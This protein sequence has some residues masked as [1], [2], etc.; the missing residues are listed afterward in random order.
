MREVEP[1]DLK[2][3]AKIAQLLIEGKKGADLDIAIQ[4]FDKS[5]VPE[6][7]TRFEAPITARHYRR[8]SSAP[9]PDTEHSHPPSVKQEEEVSTPS[10]RK[11]KARSSSSQPEASRSSPAFECP[12]P[13]PPSEADT[14][15]DFYSSP[16][17]PFSPTTTYSLTPTNPSFVSRASA[18][19]LVPT[20]H[21][22]A[23]TNNRL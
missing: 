11:A 16:S 6:V 9:V 18:R 2:R 3:C 13:S 22:S 19:D 5:H 23:V 14:E 1:K 20:S 8:S 17:S 4:E 21:L 10:M 12:T 15:S 7:V